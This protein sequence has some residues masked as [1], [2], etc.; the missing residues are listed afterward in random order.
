MLFERPLL[1]P[2]LVFM[3][4]AYTID[5]GQAKPCII[6]MTDSLRALSCQR[7]VAGGR[8]WVWWAYALECHHHCP[9]GHLV[10][11]RVSQCELLPDGTVPH[12]PFRVL[13]HAP[14]RADPGCLQR[15]HTGW[16]A[17]DCSMSLNEPVP[18]TYARA[19]INP[20]AVR[21]EHA[22]PSSHPVKVSQWSQVVAS[23]FI[24]ELQ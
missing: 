22:T 12:R 2:S 10:Q 23:Q 4:T 17:A 3:R 6:T 16:T 14:A 1:S 11:T 18:C 13:R 5:A 15:L 24:A 20:V 8:P 19:A 7:K 9:S 21:A